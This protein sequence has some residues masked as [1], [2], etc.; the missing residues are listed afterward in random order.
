[1]FP[2]ASLNSYV[3]FVS[4]VVALG[5]FV[6]GF[7]TTVISGAVPFVKNTSI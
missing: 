7:D 1:M 5:G 2:L 6:G 3:V 4:F